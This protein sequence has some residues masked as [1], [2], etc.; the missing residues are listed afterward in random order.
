MKN[1]IRTGGLAVVV[2]ALCSMAAGQVVS[3]PQGTEVRLR[4]TENISSADAK[5]GDRVNMAVLEDVT[6]GGVVVVHSGAAARGEITVAHGKRRMGRAGAVSLRV[7]SVQASDGSTLK[8]TGDERKQKGGNGALKMGVVAVLLTPSPLAPMVLLMHGHDTAMPAGTP[9]TAFTIADAT[10]G[11]GVKVQAA[12]LPVKAVVAPAVQESHAIEGYTISSTTSD[13]ASAP[14]SELS[15]A[16][17]AR[18]AKAK[19]EKK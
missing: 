3:V 9:I 11:G 13:A 7:D 19:R 12:I 16:D 18:A 14:G 4:L 6:I 5:I 1:R 2:M 15:I 8:L 17:V 10:V